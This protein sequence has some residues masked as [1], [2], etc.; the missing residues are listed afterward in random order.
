MRHEKLSPTVEKEGA[1]AALVRVKNSGAS[2]HIAKM[3][4]RLDLEIYSLGSKKQ[5]GRWS[6]SIAIFFER[7]EAHSRLTG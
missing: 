3:S 5:K 2:P 4:A 7:A 6:M 1:A